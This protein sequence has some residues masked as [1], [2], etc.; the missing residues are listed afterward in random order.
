M[1]DMAR[2]TTPGFS[3]VLVE[4]TSL[5]REGLSLIL[6]AA[7]YNVVRA[8]ERLDDDAMAALA[9]TKPDL[10]ILGAGRDLA[11]TAAQIARVKSLES[12]SL[13]AVLLDEN[14]ATL[15]SVTALFKAGANTCLSKHATGEVL[16]KSL[17]LLALG[18]HVVPQPLLRALVGAAAKTTQPAAAQ[19]LGARREPAASD[20]P[21][22][23]LSAQEPRSLRCLVE[24]CSNKSIARQFEIAEATVKVHLKAILRK[25]RLQNRTQAAIWALNNAP[26][27]HSDAERPAPKSRAGAPRS[28]AA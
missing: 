9:E 21:T 3:T 1:E 26:A 13:I 28:I 22:P 6:S 5:L 7:Q 14:N 2:A 24:G 16:V 8:S 20:I 10:L 18:Q 17:E 27:L 25:I 11:A 19:A 15:Q 23:P 12:D 4:E